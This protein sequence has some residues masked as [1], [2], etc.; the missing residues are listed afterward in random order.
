MQK[1]LQN[2][3]R[4]KLTAAQRMAVTNDRLDGKDIISNTLERDIEMIKAAG[5]GVAMG[6]GRQELKDEAD[7][8]AH[9]I[10]D[11]GLYRTMKHFGFVKG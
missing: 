8:I 2:I 1:E 6:N 4:T 9:D 5:L 10:S 3:V 7:Y 11:D